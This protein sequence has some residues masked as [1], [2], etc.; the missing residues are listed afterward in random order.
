MPKEES[1]VSFKNEK[2]TFP[3][4]F[5]IY[6]DFESTTHL[7]TVQNDNNKYHKHTVNSVGYKYNCINDEYSEPIKIINSSN[8]D[9]LL[10]NKQLVLDLE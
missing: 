3:H 7:E 8:P 4:P 9:E 5:S 1:K 10:N 6:L 2:N